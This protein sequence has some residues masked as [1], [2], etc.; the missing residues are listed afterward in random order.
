MKALPAF[1]GVGVKTRDPEKMKRE[2]AEARVGAR[3]A[4]AQEESDVITATASERSRDW[5]K[6]LR[7]FVPALP[8]NLSTEGPIGER[9]KAR[10]KEQL[11]ALSDEE[12][13][14]LEGRYAEEMRAAIE[15]VMSDPDFGSFESDAD[16]ATYLR[17]VLKRA[18]RR[19]L[20]GVRLELRG[21]QMDELQRLEEKQRMLEGKSQQPR[22][23]ETIKLGEEGRPV[24]Q[25]QPAHEDRALVE[26]R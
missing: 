2:F 21:R 13:K 24:S 7:V 19:F 20:N 25:A 16:R 26:R 14:A 8:R 5:L 3:V 23:G 12:F 15:A 6:K 9:V 22:P 4:K 1:L 11:A 18:Q 10:D 17:G